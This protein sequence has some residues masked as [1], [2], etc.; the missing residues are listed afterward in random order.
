[1]VRTRPKHTYST[2]HRTGKWCVCVCACVFCLSLC[3]P[4]M[5]IPGMC[6]KN[7]VHDVSVVLVN[8]SSSVAFST[9][10]SSVG[11]LCYIRTSRTVV[12][13]SSSHGACSTLTQWLGDDWSSHS[14]T[15]VN[16]ESGMRR[17]AALLGIRIYYNIY[18]LYTYVHVHVGLR[19]DC[20]WYAIRNC[21]VLRCV[22]PITM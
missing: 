7:S 10:P 19:P 21:G 12:I 1:M 11:H 22:L 14:H 17:V 9:A 13:T 15:A 2:K 18:Y 16:A 5:Y 3:V 6:G 20:H 4:T 8:Y